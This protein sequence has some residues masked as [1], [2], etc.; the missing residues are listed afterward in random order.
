MKSALANLIERR[1]G[2]IA[3]IGVYVIVTLV[4]GVPLYLLMR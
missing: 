3:V 4:E 1:G 2:C